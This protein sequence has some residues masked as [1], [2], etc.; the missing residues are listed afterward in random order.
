MTAISTAAPAPG[1][2]PGPGELPRRQLMAIIGGLLIAALLAAL[3]QT[4]VVTAMRTI[5]DDLDGLHL[6]AWVST[7]YLITSTATI[8]L[9]GKLGDLFGRRRMILT[10]ISIPASSGRTG[11]AYEKFKHP[12]SGYAIVGV[13]AVVQLDAAGTVTGCKVAV[14]GAG[15][16]TDDAKQVGGTI[17]G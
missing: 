16:H 14:T 6:Q 8:P 9:Y 10:A 3:D 12:A 13:A 17:Q 5:A 11:M 1:P 2:A 4:V 7:G 15:P